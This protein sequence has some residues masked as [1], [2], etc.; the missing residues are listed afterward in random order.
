M[1]DQGQSCQG[2]QARLEFF[3]WGE[4]G[5][6]SEDDQIG[7]AETSQNGQK[8]AEADEVHRR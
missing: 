7:L 8:Q 5:P 6:I 1:K 3:D 2:R 4:E